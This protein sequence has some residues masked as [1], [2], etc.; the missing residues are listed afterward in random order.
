MPQAPE[1]FI[2]RR[3]Q[4]D[5]LATALQILAICL[6]QNRTAAGGQHAGMVERQFIDDRFFD[7]P[8]TV[9]TFALKILPYGTPETRLNGVVGINKRKLEPPGELPPN[10]G[11]A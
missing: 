6:S 4:V 11:F 2:G 5:H 7:I 1:K 8:E 9:F 3:L 10:G